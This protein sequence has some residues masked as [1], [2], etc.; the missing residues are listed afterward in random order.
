MDTEPTAD[1]DL[2][3]APPGRPEG[4]AA[5]PAADA[6]APSPPPGTRSWALFWSVFTPLALV[7]ILVLA[8]LLRLPAMG[9]I[10]QE[11]LHAPRNQNALT[12]VLVPGGP[13]LAIY[14]WDEG[15][16]LHPDERFLTM[17]AAAIA[18]PEPC[19]PFFPHLGGEEQ[20]TPLE[21]SPYGCLQAYLDTANSPL[22]PR[23]HQGFEL[24][25]YGSLPMI[26]FRVSAEALNVT[27][28]AQM[29]GLGRLFSVLG[30]LL[31]ILLTFFLGKRL[32]GARAGLL[33]ALFLSLSVLNIQNAHFFT[34]D[35]ALSLLTLACVYLA[36]VI[37][38]GKGS[39]GAFVLLG[40]SFGAAVACK[41][42]V[43]LFGAIIVLAGGVRL[44][45]AVQEKG[46][47]ALQKRFRLAVLAGAVAAF[48]AAVLF[49]VVKDS[50]LV[51]NAAIATLLLVGL[52]AVG[53]I[54]WWLAAFRPQPAATR[55]LVP[56][57]RDT[58]LGLLIVL[59]LALGVFRFAQPD[60][61]NGPQLLDVPGLVKAALERPADPD[62][63]GLLE[64]IGEVVLDS[65]YRANMGTIQ[66]LVSGE[67]DYPPSHQWTERPALWFPWENMVL[68][69]LGLPLGLAAWAGV[70]LAGWQIFRSRNLRFV[71][72]FA[73]TV[74]FFTYQGVQFVKTMRY[75]LPLYPLL[76]VFAAAL[77]LRLWDRARAREAR[78]RWRTW[79]GGALLGVVVLGTALW[80][81][82]FV[83][84]YYRPITRAT[85]SRW[86]YQNIA[87][88][89][90]AWLT[91]SDG[92]QVPIA[93]P[94]AQLYAPTSPA[95][96]TA[97]SLDS[98]GTA[99][100]LTVAHLQD[101]TGSAGRE[102]LEAAI[103]A[104]PAGRQVLAHGI[105]SG[106]FSGPAGDAAPG[107]VT[108]APLR[109]EAGRTYYLR[110]QGR[111]GIFIT[112]A[113][114][115]ANEYWDDPVPMRVD[116][117]DGFA[118]TANGYRGLMLSPYGEDSPEKVDELLHQLANTDYLCLT[119]NRLYDSIPRLPMRYPATTRYYQALFD[120]SLGFERIAT[121]TSYPSLF[122]LGVPAGLA[123]T[124]DEERAALPGWFGLAIPDQGAEEAFSVYDHPK[125][126]IFRRTAA[127]DI[128][129][130]REL[131]TA[132]IDWNRI[133]RIRPIE[134]PEW[135]LRQFLQ[136]IGLGGTTQGDSQ[137]EPPAPDLMLTEQEWQTQLQGGTWSELFDPDGWT[138]RLALPVW[139]LFV[140]LLG[141]A[142]LPLSNGLF[143]RL[144]DGGY[145]PAKALGLL[146][147]GY[148][149]WLLAASKLLPY[150]RGTIALVLG[151]LVVLGAVVG[152]LRRAEIR[153]LFRDR[154]RLLLL[155]EGV[156]LVGFLIFLLIRLGNPD[157]WH[158]Y[159]GGEK[160]MDFAYLN[161]VLR[162]T[163]FP[164][165]DPWFAGG[166]LNYYYF[167]YIV[168]ATPIKL[169][170]IVPGVAYNL[171][172]PLLYGLTC[173]GAFTVAYHLVDRKRRTGSGRKRWPAVAGLAG[174]AFVALLGN[175]GQLNLFADKIGQ[176]AG[177]QFESS[178]PYLAPAVKLVAGLPQVLREGLPIGSGSLYWDASRVIVQHADGPVRGGEIN[179]F[180]FFTFLYADLHAHMI[181]LPFTL[182]ALTMVI[183]LLRT[184]RQEDLPRS[185]PA[186]GPS[187][188]QALERAGAG[189]PAEPAGAPAEGIPP[190]RSAPAGRDGHALRDLWALLPPPW[191]LLGLLL[192][193]GALRCANLWDFPTYWLVAVGGWAVALYER[194]RRIDWRMLVSVLG[195]AAMLW[196]LSTLLFQPFWARWG[197]YYNSLIPWEGELT[198]V[199]EYVSINGL[200]L[201]ILG[202]YLVGEALGEGSREA[203]LRLFGLGVRYWDRLP[204]LVRRLRRWGRAPTALPIL[205]AAGGGLLL[206]EL[207]LHLAGLPLIAWLVL[208]AALGLILF[209]RPREEGEGRLVAML[210]LAGL[211]VS[212]AIEFLVI[213]GDIG[214]MNTFFKFYL[215]IWVLWGVAAA[216]VLPRLW[217]RT[218]RWSRPARNIWRGALFALVAVCALYPLTA[219][220]AKIEDRFAGSTLGPGLDGEAFMQSETLSM[221][222]G[223]VVLAEDYGA[224]RW[225]EE[226]VA[227]S[228][229]ILE[230]SIGT[231]Y[232]NFG[233]R[234]S[235]FTGLPTVLGWDWHQKQQRA[236][237]ER[238]VVEERLHDVALLYNGDDIAQTLDL[239][240]QYRVSYIVVGQLERYYYAAQGLAK[241]ERM[242]GTYLERVYP[243]AA[244]LP[245]TAAAPAPPPTV[246]P[247]PSPAASSTRYPGPT[248]QP[249]QATEASTPAPATTE[250]TVI[251]RVLPNVWED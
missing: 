241:F 243:A 4:A 74:L 160:P 147:L 14:P 40:L 43:V 223:P 134:V 49:L 118:T 218:Q 212:G 103:V 199:W 189:G 1:L 87:T 248:P 108:F 25:V 13:Y 66:A 68:W 139:L 144:A 245:G 172:I 238:P 92:R 18:T 203:P 168:V 177:L 23:N 78:P 137:Q 65:R 50:S 104:D 61:F 209:L 5:P 196:F 166:Y 59:V 107:V 194:R 116:G 55:V 75:F 6:S 70:G 26:V 240:R 11:E 127:F 206:I 231:G 136:Q 141:L 191:L 219:T 197:E 232:R 57:L 63:P 143:G 42:N 175:L 46:S 22:N 173:A 28:F 142:V 155:E 8:A 36:V 19:R 30:D 88:D 81:W 24:W 99:T 100:G 64:R 38:E 220:P 151:L 198:Q 10:G 251:Y 148:L 180:P 113:V 94:N 125:V 48:L 157:L 101:V 150:S 170:G 237:T 239:L 214:R 98:A 106:D 129:R 7:G 184:H 52:V 84:I 115:M 96:T 123:A 114:A 179:E 225:L 195:L 247:Y 131:L 53:F 121:F 190:A 31:T 227:G 222:H 250:G 146:L 79:A 183:A 47:Q 58:L 71:V 128:E 140:E 86:I 145:L 234:I 167:G 120:G 119:S 85:A 95:T 149:S 105:V 109:L 182:L 181:A 178:I 132:G 89:R 62:G 249:L 2:A 216:A 67:M 9:I 122:A 124:S 246:S 15:L 35:I 224:I 211:G 164:P 17:V 37:A 161:A 152:W 69:G 215:Q 44:W 162:S 51:R 80:A 229:V 202:S 187:A 34:V 158:P 217:R 77:L 176:V 171:V 133:E 169:T 242:V 117:R 93:I 33:A 233:S 207:A 163:T 102:L 165:Y 208:L 135:R 112:W 20:I 210:A 192:V 201:F 32:A 186:A 82:G 200:A 154:W 72:P 213:R 244:A 27:G 3:A 56:V 16:G 138:S 193:L 60:A 91:L 228:P 230:A 110:L 45:R 83:Q 41:I 156:F 126:Q 235:F 21:G 97:F 221:E 90:G 159:F 111:Q 205:L 29:T 76:C 174:A 73:W 153:A 236:A 185:P 12:V 204:T 130:A 54:C 188:E 226:N 39:Y